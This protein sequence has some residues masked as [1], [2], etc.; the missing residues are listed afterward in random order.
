MRQSDRQT[1]NLEGS[2]NEKKIQTDNR[3]TDEEREDKTCVR[4]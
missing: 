4:Y 1:Q 2:E 3:P